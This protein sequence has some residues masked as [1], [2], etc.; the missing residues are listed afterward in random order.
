MIR[1]RSD[2]VRLGS[3]FSIALTA[4]AVVGSIFCPPVD[5]L[6]PAPARYPSAEINTRGPRTAPNRRFGARTVQHSETPV[7]TGE[8]FKKLRSV[9]ERRECRRGNFF[10]GNR[11][12]S[13]AGQPPAVPEA[14]GGVLPLCY[15]FGHPNGGLRKRT[16]ET[17]SASP[18]VGRSRKQ[19]AI[20]GQYR[21]YRLN[22][23]VEKW[24]ARR[25]S[26]A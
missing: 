2:G 9:S 3:A 6:V 4:S 23:G 18:T 26:N 24:Y 22:P 16:N 13:S 1:A 11:K 21:Y 12:G 15:L 14:R 10:H 7:C 17:A 8:A 25:G 20:I 5:V 19:P